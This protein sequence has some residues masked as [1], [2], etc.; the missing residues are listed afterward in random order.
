MSS[1]LTCWRVQFTQSRLFN[2]DYSVHSVQIIQYTQFRLLSTQ[3]RLFST[4]NL[5]YS[6]HSVQI[7]QYIQS[8]L[9]STLSLDYSVLILDYSVHS[10]QIIQY[11]QSRLFSKL[12][13]DYSVH[14]FLI[15]QY[16][17]FRKVIL[18]RSE[19]SVQIIQYKWSRLFCTGCHRILWPLRI[20]Q[21]LGSPDTQSQNFGFFSHA[22]F[23][24]A[25]KMSEI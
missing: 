10:V 17:L 20:F 11:T 21:F 13:L 8:R 7:I 2:I 12:S 25:S 5:D 1:T 6:V 15:V 24:L 14:S 4:L 22:Q 23:M 9:F 18:D 19:H 3:S 16:R